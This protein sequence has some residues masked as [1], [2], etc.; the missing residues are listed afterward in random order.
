VLS[1]CYLSGI[2]LAF[3]LASGIASGLASGIALAFGLASGIASG[4]ASGIALAFGLASGFALLFYLRFG[5]GFCFLAK[6]HFFFLAKT[7]GF[8]YGFALALSWLCASRICIALLMSCRALVITALLAASILTSTGLPSSPLA[9]P[10]FSSSNLPSA[11]FSIWR[12]CSLWI[13]LFCFCVP[14]DLLIYVPDY[15]CR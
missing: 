15:F 4:L 7:D 6:N 13:C 2:A 9:M 1:F 3:G 5:F 11:V 12:V 10:V 8:C 14:V